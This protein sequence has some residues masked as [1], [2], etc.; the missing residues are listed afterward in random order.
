MDGGQMNPRER[1]LAA[2]RHQPVNDGKSTAFPTD[3]WATPEVWRRLYAYFNTSDPHEVFDRLG[4]D[5]IVEIHPR[6]AGPKGAGPLPEL[7]YDE[8]GMGYRPQAYSSEFGSGEYDEQVY[9]P[10]ARAQ[11]I[12][13]LQAFPWPSP[14]DYDYSG[15]VS[16]AESWPDRAIGS[17]YTALFYWHNRLRGLEQSLMDPLERPDFTHYLI[18][19]LSEFFTEYHRRIFETLKGRMD[20]TQVTDDFG[21]QHGL[22]ISPRIF[23]VFYRQKM[24]RAIDLAKSFGVMVF[25]HDDGDMRKL[26]PRLVEMGVDVLNPIQW[27]CGNWDLD[28]MK[29]LYGGRLCF[30]SGVDNQHTLPFGTPDDVR[31]EVR[32]LKDT[33]G[34][35]GTGLIIAPCHNLQSV[36]PME[37]ILALFAEARE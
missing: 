1:I 6:Y 23:D 5:G 18:D 34:K 27:R 11:T 15:L 9:F 16:Q 19:R 10:M 22:L 37:N 26:L 3:M 13:D 31:R 14:D 33:L 12:E 17:G 20:F 7:H 25:H 4:V 21:A 30:H 36:T 35:D 32:W 24:Q 28:Q 2:A 29:D 8:W